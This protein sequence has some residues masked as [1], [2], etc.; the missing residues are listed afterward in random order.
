MSQFFR[1]RVESLEGRVLLAVA[2]LANAA[3]EAH[4]EHD[5]PIA[6]TSAPAPASSGELPAVFVSVEPQDTCNVLVVCVLSDQPTQ[7]VSVDG[8][9]GEWTDFNGFVRLQVSLDSRTI[10]LRITDANGA[11]LPTLRIVLDDQGNVIAQ[12]WN[13]SNSSSGVAIG[14]SPPSL[15]H[16]HSTTGTNSTNSL[17]SVGMLH[18]SHESPTLPATVHD[19]ASHM[20]V[21][22][23]SSSAHVVSR[24]PLEPIPGVTDDRDSSHGSS[25]KSAAED[26]APTA[27]PN[28]NA[29][30]HEPTDDVDAVW[31]EPTS[32]GDLS[33]IDFDVPHVID[34]LARQIVPRTNAHA[35][36]IQAPEIPAAMPAQPRSHAIATESAQDDDDQDSS[37]SGW[38]LAAL[39]ALAA[40]SGAA[41]VLLERRRKKEGMRDEG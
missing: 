34:L 9:E 19:D 24:T 5:V 1:P 38:K 29:S 28:S 6:E 17:A 36:A 22:S 40:T 33:A 14:V 11:A 37:I 2:D 7:N 16:N 32:G 12:S 26:D 25:S 31:A 41:A 30:A 10:D 4:S 21:T 23:R 20:L 39:G 3:S 35:V 18:E 15:D 13:A 27:S 8:G